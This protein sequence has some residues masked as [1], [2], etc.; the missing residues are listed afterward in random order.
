MKSS[1]L[2]LT[3]FALTF[4]NLSAGPLIPNIDQS[5]SET[6]T[7]LV[8]K[9]LQKAQQFERGHPDSAAYYYKQ[10]LQT[11]SNTRDTQNIGTAFVSLFKLHIK[12]GKYEDAFDLAQEETR[13]GKKWASRELQLKGYNN[14]AIA[15]QYLNDYQMAADFYLKAAGISDKMGD[16]A[17]EAKILDNMSSLFLRLK[18]YKA[19]YTYGSQSYNISRQRNDSLYMISGLISMGDAEAGMEKYD[20]ALADFNKVEII[21]LR[22]N[23]ILKVMLAKGN[24]GLI[25]IKTGKV[26]LA[27]S[28]FSDVLRLAKKND[29]P[30][31]VA[32]ALN[33]LASSEMVNKNYGKAEQYAREAIARAQKQKLGAELAEMYDNISAIKQKLGKSAEALTY[34][35][36]YEQINDSLMNIQIKTNISRMNIQYNTAKKDKEILQQKLQLTE[37]QAAIQKRNTWLLLFL[38]IMIAFAVILITLSRNYSNKRKLHAQT[39]LSMQKEQEVVRLKAL[40][41]GKDEERQRISSEMHD[42]IGS[43]LTSILFLSNHLKD[44]FPS[45]QTETLEKITNNANSLISKMNE[46]IW[47]MNTDYDTLEDLVA[48]LRHHAGELLEN[49]NI[50]YHFHIPPIIPDVNLSGEERRNIYL[51]VIEALHNIIKHAQADEVNISFSFDDSIHVSICDNGKGFVDEQVRRFGNGLKNMKQRMESI[52]GNFNIKNDQGVTI[53]LSLPLAG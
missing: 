25:Y 23:E 39:L 14:T 43:G 11:A 38:I 35:N 37:N 18:N 19:A 4:L 49:A 27:T 12:K 47:A 31:M 42:D 8:K 21:A 5:A 7:I 34:K 10:A 6:D 51:V 13:I 33:G 3:T 15:Y 46:I 20:S 9:Y 41:E 22:I 50:N 24:K 26:D 29:Y 1:L 48:Y 52:A 28:E 44:S 40:M 32:I 53:Q 36:L 17:L 2:L 30:Y 16:H 45:S